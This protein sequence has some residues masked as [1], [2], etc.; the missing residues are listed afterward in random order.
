MVCT[1]NCFKI[2]LKK[3]VLKILIPYPY[4]KGPLLHPFLHSH[5]DKACVKN[6]PQCQISNRNIFCWNKKWFRHVPLN[7]YQRM[8]ILSLIKTFTRISWEF[9]VC[10][11]LVNMEI[12]LIFIFE[13]RFFPF[14][15]YQKNYPSKQY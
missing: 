10:S 6:K 14:L 9:I 7:E 5:K 1:S 3:V 11:I 4:M 15:V 2:V 12:F 13:I 8:C